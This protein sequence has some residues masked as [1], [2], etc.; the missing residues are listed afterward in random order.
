MTKL[1]IFVMVC[2]GLSGCAEMAERRQ[3]MAEQ[4]Q[5]Q[6]EAFQQDWDAMTPEQRMQYQLAQQQMGIQRQQLAMQQQQA[7]QQQIADALKLTPPQ[8]LNFNQPRT[9]NCTSNQAGNT[10][11]TNCN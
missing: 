5:A 1:L 4:R 3:A 2:T 11:Y 7:Q 6:Q 10:V 9:I 8:P